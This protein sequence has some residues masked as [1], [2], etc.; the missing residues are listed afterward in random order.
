MMIDLFSYI[1]SHKVGTSMDAADKM[2]KS[3]HYWE[4]RV[5]ETLRDKAMTTEELTELLQAQSK[6]VQP[7]TSRLRSK[8]KIRDSGMRRMNRDN[9]KVI[10]WVIA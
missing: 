3:A 8:G 9:N 2:R 1:P 10:V 6:R 4:N 7:A 5:M